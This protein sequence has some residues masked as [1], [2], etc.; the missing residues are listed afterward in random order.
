MRRGITGK[1]SAPL[2]MVHKG[3]GSGTASLARPGCGCMP[4]L[5]ALAQRGHEVDQ[6]L[7]RNQY[8]NRN[9][10]LFLSGAESI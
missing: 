1:N 10:G 5:D 3:C 6:R 8:P 9:Q 2:W 4:R 7:R